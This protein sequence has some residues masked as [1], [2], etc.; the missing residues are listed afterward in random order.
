MTFNL[1][2]FIKKYTL[3]IIAIVVIIFLG[4]IIYLQKL[5][6]SG[7][8]VSKDAVELHTS[9]IFMAGMTI[10][11]FTLFPLYFVNSKISTLWEKKLFNDY[12]E[13]VAYS[14]YMIRYASLM[15]LLILPVEFFGYIRDLYLH[16]T[17]QSLLRFLQIQILNFL[18]MWII[19]AAITYVVVWIIRRHSK[20]WWKALSIT[21]AVFIIFSNVL[22]PTAIEPLVSKVKPLDRPSYEASINEIFDKAKMKPVGIYVVE[23]SR[24]TNKLNAHMTGILGAQRVVLW[25]TIFNSLNKEEIISVIAHEIGHYKYGHIWINSFW[26]IGKLTLIYY[27]AF[28]IIQL[29]KTKKLLPE[30][31]KPWL[32]ARNIPIFLLCLQIALSVFIPLDNIIS[33]NQERQADTYEVMLIED[34]KWPISALN[35]VEMSNLSLPEYSNIYKVLFQTHPTTSERVELYKNILKPE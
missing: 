33:R 22:Y 31:D 32:Y 15:F 29:E 34:S 35:K 14:I 23:K 9:T 24:D 27:L 17:N 26:A 13:P 30:K 25:D 20:D 7:V 5:V 10:L 16:L 6:N 2:T 8:V 11:A 3:T 4:E 28:R 18:M 21:T 12:I 1:D 19:P